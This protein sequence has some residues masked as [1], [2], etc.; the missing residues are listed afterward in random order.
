LGTKALARVKLSAFVAMNS[1]HCASKRPRL[2]GSSPRYSRNSV[3]RD[4]QEVAVLR[5]LCV[6]VT[7]TLLPPV[8]NFFSGCA[9][10]DLRYI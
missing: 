7:Q 8:L 4:Q 6:I 2:T 10:W 3:A 5:L 9:R 1:L